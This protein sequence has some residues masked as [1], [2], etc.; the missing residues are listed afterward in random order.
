MQ[1]KVIPT[2]SMVTPID[3]LLKEP[4][5]E[6][7]QPSSTQGTIV[8]LGNKNS[9]GYYFF[10][11]PDPPSPVTPAKGKRLM[12]FARPNAGGFEHARVVPWNPPFSRKFTQ[13]FCT[14]H[15]CN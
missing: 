7:Q 15:L 13:C 1:T 14:P 12:A 10:C 2:S 9:L 8:R 6:E 4:E 3:M 11:Y 5:L